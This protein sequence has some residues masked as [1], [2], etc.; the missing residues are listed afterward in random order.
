MSVTRKVKLALEAEHYA[1]T[2]AV[3]WPEASIA[4]FETVTPFEM[5]G[6]H[7]EVQAAAL[8][9]A[10]ALKVHELMKQKRMNKSAMAARMR[11]SRAAVTSSFLIPP[12]YFP[13]G[14]GSE[15]TIKISQSALSARS[16]EVDCL[17]TNFLILNFYFRLSYRVS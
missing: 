12:S 14:C 5:E 15:R 3:T 11:T 13:I 6:L 2:L 9:R 7:E 17:A 8:K 16:F 4:M 10:V 1:T